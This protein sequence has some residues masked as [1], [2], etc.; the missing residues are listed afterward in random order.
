MT[1]TLKPEVV[2]A[3]GGATL[4]GQVGKAFVKGAAKEAAKQVQNRTGVAKYMV[5]PIQPITTWHGSPHTM[6]PTDNNPLGEFSNERIGTGEG[7]QAYGVGHYVAEAP[8]VA[9][10]FRGA[11][12]HKGTLD[13]EYE[14]GQRGIPLD[15]ES[16]IEFMRQS[17][18][19]VS[20]EKAATSF[21]YAN[22]AAR[23]L[24]QAKLAQLFKDYKESKQGS[25]YKVDLPDEHVA[26]MID[27]YKPINEQSPYVLEALG[28]AGINAES[29][30]MA[31]PMA[32]GQESHLQKHGITGIRYLDNA[33]IGSKGVG[34]SNFVVFD[35]KHLNILERNPKYAKGGKIASAGGDWL[36]KKLVQYQEQARPLSKAENI[37]AGLYH[38][39]GGG[40]KLVKPLSEMTSTKVINTPMVP[41]KIISPE[42]LYGSY[43]VPAVGDRTAAGSLLTHIGGDKLPNPVQLEGGADF[44]RTH[45]PYG[46]AWAA[47]K[48]A[49][50]NLSEQIRDAAASGR[51]IYMPHV[52]MG[53]TSGDF[54]TMMSNSLLEQIANSK[55]TKKA[56]KEFD[57][58]VKSVRPEFKGLLHPETRDMLNDNGALRL[59]FINKLGLKKQIDAGF[60]DLAATRAAIAE[61]EL[62]TAPVHSSGFTIAK[63]DPAGGIITDPASPVHTSYNTQLAGKY[64]GGFAAQP[65]R[66][67]MFPTFYNERRAAGLPE[68]GDTRS[69]QLNHPGQAANQEWLDSVMGWME[70]NPGVK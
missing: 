37:A 4:L 13:L 63:M 53:H 68:P 15:R 34:T 51:D 57:N 33:S 28:R 60:P 69:F 27:W 1:I 26:K 22:S 61:P 10:R 54:S 32:R 17:R 38:P 58:S 25:L 5:N 52:S 36:A 59:A 65:P 14:S 18:P 35:P 40:T 23:N 16:R 46:A 24:D 64:V 50:S 70:K 7:V 55:I 56:I 6:K 3:A 48:G 66:S 2:D 31:G 41:R 8:K 49:A 12:G 11:L 42:D 39:I 21:Q 20:P 67:V 45:A 47:D 43:I 19:D 29:S 9:E 44:M 62:L 30:A